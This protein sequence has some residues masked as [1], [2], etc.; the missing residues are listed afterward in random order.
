MD[1]VHALIFCFLL[2]QMSIVAAQSG[3][4]P[5]TTATIAENNH[6]GAVVA[7]I[8]IE[9]GVTLT[10]SPNNPPDFPFAIDGNQLIA[11]SV[12]DFETMISP[13]MVGIVCTRETSVDYTIYVFVQNVND[14]P[15]VFDKI[16]YTPTINEMSPIGSTVGNF[17]ATDQDQ[18]QL[19]YRLTTESTYFKLKLPTIP[20]ILVD[21]Q[22]D[23]D[24]IKQVELVLQAQDTKFD[25]PPE[26]ISFTATTTIM[27]S[28]L[29]IDNRPPWYQPCS[30]REVG[31]TV[32]CESSGYTGRVYLNEQETGALPLKPGPLYA[33]DGDMGIDEDITYSFLSGDE[34]NLLEINPNT[35]NVTM[36]RP[37]DVLGPI[38]L[39]VLAAQ[40]TNVHQFTTTSLTISVQVES[41][42]APQFQRPQY[43]ALITSKGSMA[44]DPR[45]QQ[46]LQI[47]ATDQ[48]YASTGGLNPHMTYSVEGSSSFA[49]V[50]GYLFMTEDL[51]EDTLSL[52]IL[53]KDTSNDETA[54]AQLQV[55]LKLGS[56]TTSLPLSTTDIMTITSVGQSTSNSKTTH[57]ILPTTNEHSSLS[58]GVSA[59]SHSLTKMPSG[60]FRGSDMAALSATLGVLLFVCLLVIGLLVCHVRR[61]KADWK[62]IQEVT[63]FRSSLGQSSGGPK[64]GVQYTNEAFHKDEDGSSVGSGGP[65]VGNTTAGGYP[66]KMDWNHPSKEVPQ[67]SSAPLPPLLPDASDNNSDKADDEKDVK[68]ILTKERRVEEGYKSVWFKE[69]ID[70]NA[71]EEVVIIPDSREEDSDEE[72]EEQNVSEMKRYR[73]KAPKVGFADTD[74]DSGLGVKMDNPGE[75]SENNHDLNVDL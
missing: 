31:G 40:R 35:G 43:E 18:D 59:T 68:P 74:L 26:D 45:N 48:D 66:P 33:I 36:L 38:S 70:P 25:S 73:M 56:S 2:I 75:D 3:C 57:E 13:F 50:G 52:Q 63:M 24:K 20:E 69:D 32:V 28:I 19:Y 42:H 34:D 55:E 71:K 17:D 15:P 53:A 7:T 41:L 37:A 27:I 11:T 47:L 49:I 58:T 16:L 9:T 29:D 12:L 54:T 8:P 72:D 4:S 10:Y 1:R 22:L 44:I 39:T 65:E 67:R 6:V 14:N 30:R 51:P 5:N 62:K 60:E 61:G 23:Y 46:P 64:E 21:A